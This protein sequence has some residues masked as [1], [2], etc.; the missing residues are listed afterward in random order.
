MT[1]RVEERVGGGHSRERCCLEESREAAFAGIVLKPSS[2]LYT[3]L[4]KQQ[5]KEDVNNR[6]K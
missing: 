2:L 3:E 5:F 4:G 1:H 6:V